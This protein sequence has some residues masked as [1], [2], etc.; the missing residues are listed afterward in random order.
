MRGGLVYM[1]DNLWD[2]ARV[3]D[4]RTGQVRIVAGD[5]DMNVHQTP[6]GDGGPATSA[7]L[8]NR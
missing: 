5:A 7:R 3:L 2:V 6:R 1:A 4:T 8:V